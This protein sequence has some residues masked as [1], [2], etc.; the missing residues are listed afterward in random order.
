MRQ[1]IATVVIVVLW[2]A[3]AVQCAETVSAATIA[4][5]VE[6]TSESVVY[7]EGDKSCGSGFVM[8]TGKHIEIY[9]NHHVMKTDPASSHP[10]CSSR[11]RTSAICSRRSS[12]RAISSLRRLREPRMPSRPPSA[13]TWAT[14]GWRSAAREI[15]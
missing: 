10:S 13:A 2:A 8:K 1:R 5:L 4:D 11:R 9:T 14:W 6:Q 3:L 12:R 7:I 15:S